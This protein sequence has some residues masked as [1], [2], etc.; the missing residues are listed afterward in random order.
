MTNA[1]TNASGSIAQAAT[2]PSPA[3]PA[4]ARTRLLL[5]GPIVAT[6]LRLAAPNVRAPD[7]AAGGLP[8]RIGPYRVVDVLAVSQRLI[9]G[10]SPGGGRRPSRRFVASWL[11]ATCWRI[12][13]DCWWLISYWPLALMTLAAPLRKP[14]YELP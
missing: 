3:K 11:C 9:G 13:C 7:G 5:E 2:T 4:A 10:P 1:V 6:L 14:P 8:E 12:S